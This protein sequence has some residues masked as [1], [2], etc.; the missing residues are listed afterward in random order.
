MMPRR[1]AV[2]HRPHAPGAAPEAARV[3][4]KN[5]G[6]SRLRRY[7]SLHI[8]AWW[9]SLGRIARA[10]LASFMTIAVIGIALA[11]PG[12]FLTLLANMQKITAGWEGNM[13]ELSVFLSKDLSNDAAA[14][15]TTEL[16][17]WAEV[18]SVRHITPEQ[19]LAEF[20]RTLGGDDWLTL[21]G[22]N[23]LPGVLVVR[24]TVEQAAPERVQS[25]AERLRDLPEVESVQVDME[26]LQRLHAIMALIERGV[27]ILAGLLALAVLLI[28]GNTIRL[29][30]ESRRDEIIVLK[31]L[32]ATDA[33]VRRPYLYAGAWYG[34]FG[35]VVAVALVS[36]VLW[37][38][39]KPVAQ[40]AAL[41]HSDIVLGWLDWVTA[42]GL[43][44]GAVVLGYG[45]ARLTVARHLRRIEPD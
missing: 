37:G 14:A 41:Y 24:P 36:A 3:R 32:G 2:T 44:L 45:G 21:L 16:E 15:L 42:A 28:V 33:F 5:S 39:S 10:P 27:W 22:S 6:S 7:L 19:G 23:P 30:L 25:L 38:L 18:E 40:L 9:G 17:S 34:I 43:L 12:T 8:Q 29:T 11:L 35:G 26:W 31:L 4:R 20:Q 1:R 13:T